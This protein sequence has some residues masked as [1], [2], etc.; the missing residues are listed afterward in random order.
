[1]LK[2][3]IEW[4][5]GV[6]VP[7]GVAVCACAVLIGGWLWLDSRYASAADVERSTTQTHQKIEQKAKEIEKRQ[8]AIEARSVSTEKRMLE[9][10]IFRIRMKITGNKADNVDKA[11]L[12]HYEKQV[13]ELRTEIVDLRKKSE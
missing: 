10:E 6:R 9:N 2:T 5:N 3:V 7:L 8:Y 1:M 12:Q 11:M 4:L 13:D